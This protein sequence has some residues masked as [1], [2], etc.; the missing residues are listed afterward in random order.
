MVLLVAFVATFVLV[1]SA[2]LLLFYRDTV[3]DRLQAVLH[4]QAES[5]WSRLGRFWGRPTAVETIIKPFENVLPRSPEEITVLQ[6]RLIRAGYR[7]PIAVNMFY[8]A[9]V[10]VPLAKVLLAT[11]TRAYEAGPFF[12][13]GV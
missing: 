5:S 9:K 2:G 12:V 3:L 8:A 10:M 4:P 7:K 11:V 6:K 13:Y 1:L